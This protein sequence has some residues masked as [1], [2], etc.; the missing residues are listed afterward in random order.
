MSAVY[1][2]TRNN[3]IEKQFS[4]S[5]MKQLTRYLWAAFGRFV[6]TADGGAVA[7]SSKLLY[8]TDLATAPSSLSACRRGQTCSL[9]VTS[10]ENISARVWVDCP[11]RRLQR[12]PFVFRLAAREG[13]SVFVLIIFI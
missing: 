11:K 8:G 5:A 1:K 4:K 2:V 7:N 13:N 10:L 3:A 9:K 6:E 12:R